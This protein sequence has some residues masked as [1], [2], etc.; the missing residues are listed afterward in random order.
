MNRDT[1]DLVNRTYFGL[2][3]RR[4]CGVVLCFL[5]VV[6]V[7]IWLVLYSEMVRLRTLDIMSTNSIG[8]PKAIRFRGSP[9]VA[10]FQVHWTI[11]RMEFENCNSIVVENWLNSNAPH[12]LGVFEHRSKSAFRVPSSIV[13]V[14]TDSSET[15]ALMKF[16][17]DRQLQTFHCVSS[18]GYAA[19]HLDI[20][21][22]TEVDKLVAVSNEL[23]NLGLIGFKIEDTQELSRLRQLKTIALDGC[24]GDF[25]F[26]RSL[27][28]LEFVS[29][30]A[31]KYDPITM[32]TTLKSLPNLQTL[33][34]DDSPEGNSVQKILEPSIQGRGGHILGKMQ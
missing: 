27:K 23:T 14:R 18:W 11:E 13:S 5:T 30:V 3:P 28:K 7:A 31:T 4:A 9:S 20:P 10:A 15:F 32:G 33:C 29:L 34:V 16:S 19:E 26:L 8:L 25:G 12:E 6:A 24:S 21:R 22:F 17:S 2:P 1:P